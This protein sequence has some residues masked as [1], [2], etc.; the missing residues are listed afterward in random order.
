MDNFPNP[1]MAPE[2]WVDDFPN[3]TENFR[4]PGDGAINRLIFSGAGAG[5]FCRIFSESEDGAADYDKCKFPNKAKNF[6]KAP[7]YNTVPA[8]H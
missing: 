7:E 5:M 6:R 3:N 8:P 4:I 2:I 1:R